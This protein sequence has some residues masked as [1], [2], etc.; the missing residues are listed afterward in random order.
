MA[1]FRALFAYGFEPTCRSTSLLCVQ[2][3]CLFRSPLL[4]EKIASQRKRVLLR[5]GLLLHLLELPLPLRVLAAKVAAGLG[6]SQPPQANPTL[7]RVRPCPA[8][9]APSWPPARVPAASSHPHLPPPRASSSES[10]EREIKRKELNGTNQPPIRRTHEPQ[11]PAAWCLWAA[12]PQKGFCKK[13]DVSPARHQPV[14]DSLLDERSKRCLDS[15]CS[16]SHGLWAN[17]WRVRQKSPFL[18]R[19]ARLGAGLHA[20]PTAGKLFPERGAPRQWVP[21]QA[22][23][24]KV[25]PHE[26]AGDTDTR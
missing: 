22:L 20:F 17:C 16:N 9:L 24:D 2:C 26:W 15:A 5:F 3:T 7:A 23:R 18:R 14:C 8:P 6:G 4:T 25:D 11:R 12:A 13:G 1:S 10:Q 19:V 21:L